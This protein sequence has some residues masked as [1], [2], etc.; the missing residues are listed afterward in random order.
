M[1]VK[2]DRLSRY[3]KRN[4]GYPRSKPAQ[5]ILDS[6][7]LNNRNDLKSKIRRVRGSLDS[8]LNYHSQAGHKAD[9][10]NM[11][12]TLGIRVKKKLKNQF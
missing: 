3:F 5:Q 2:P 1:D 7:N 8:N 4:S 12:D 9:R 6:I 11:N 10:S